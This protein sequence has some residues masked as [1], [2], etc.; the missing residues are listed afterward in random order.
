MNPSNILNGADRLRHHT[1]FNSEKYEDERSHEVVGTNFQEP[2]RHIQ[3]NPYM[4][5]KL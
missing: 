5:L 2:L 1:P 4:N 3:V